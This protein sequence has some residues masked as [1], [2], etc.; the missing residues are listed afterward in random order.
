MFKIWN[1]VELLINSEVITTSGFSEIIVEVLK[2]PIGVG[3]VEKIIRIWNQ[4]KMLINGEV[5]T[6]SGF[7]ESQFRGSKRFN[8]SGYSEK[9]VYDLKSGRN[10][11]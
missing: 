5:I 1:K 9:I 11:N 10:V 6:T 3:M 2:H 4:A 7:Y 8:W